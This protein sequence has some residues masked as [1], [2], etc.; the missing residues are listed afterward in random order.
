VARI[1]CLFIFLFSFRY[2]LSSEENA[3]AELSSAA[4]RFHLRHGFLIVVPVQIGSEANLKFILDTGTSRTIVDRR[5]ARRLG[6][7]RGSPDETI[8]LHKS[9]KV[10]SAVFPEVRFGPIRATNAT[11]LIADVSSLSEFADGVDGLLGL[12]MFWERKISIDYDL[13]TL[14]VESASK[15][16]GDSVQR[17]GILCIT[18]AAQISGK[19]VRLVV[20]TGMK[21]VLVFED[22]IRKLLPGLPASR[23]MQ[24]LLGRTA[25][26]SQTVLEKLR[27]GTAEIKNIDIF[28]LSS[29]PAG[30]PPDIDGVLGTETLKARRLTLDFSHSGVT[31][32][33]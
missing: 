15:E 10:E 19:P 30:V 14:M 16:T 9:Q 17:G 3:I 18:T 4:V 8:C 12:D 23:S 1:L 20:D 33:H 27:V 28:L 25:P 21:G 5:V 31:W 24:A 7:R 29:A 2:P 32:Q 26:G 11:L 22:R 13:K 6:I